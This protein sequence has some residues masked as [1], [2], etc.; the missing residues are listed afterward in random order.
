[1]LSVEWSCNLWIDLSSLFL[2]TCLLMT[3]HPEVCDFF[4]FSQPVMP[5]TSRLG[6]GKSPQSQKAQT[7]SEGL[8]FQS[9][10]EEPM[11]FAPIPNDALSSPSRDFRGG[12]PAPFPPSVSSTFSVGMFPTSASCAKGH[13]PS[14][15]RAESNLRQPAS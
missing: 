15:A 14:P 13:P 1:M 6:A 2:M 5:E 9:A 10:A 3:C 12:N 4:V 11:Y 8:R 7:L